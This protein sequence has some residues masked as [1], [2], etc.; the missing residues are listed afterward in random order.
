ML[1]DYIN[2]A[3][4]I[5]NSYLVRTL[6]SKSEDLELT[7][8]EYANTLTQKYG[9]NGKVDMIRFFTINFDEEKEFRNF[10]EILLLKTISDGNFKEGISVDELGEPYFY[11]KNLVLKEELKN[12]NNLEHL[13]VRFPK[14][15]WYLD[16]DIINN[17]ETID[18]L[19]ELIVLGFDAIE[20]T[21]NEML[22]REMNLLK[23]SGENIMLKCK[24]TKSLQKVLA[25][26]SNLK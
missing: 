26:V 20:E 4:N 9:F 5:R 2:L 3:Q 12:K 22:Y 21:I 24:K 16:D 11:L 14:Y 6:S 8:Y 18:I 23:S 10:L 19:V 7:N 1:Y 17:E 25:Q 13:L 15:L